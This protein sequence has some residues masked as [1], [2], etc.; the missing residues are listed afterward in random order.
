MEG[1]CCPTLP[2]VLDVLSPGFG[3]GVYFCHRAL[4]HWHAGGEQGEWSCWTLNSKAFS[5]AQQE[6]LSK[7]CALFFGVPSSQPRA[8]GDWTGARTLWPNVNPQKTARGPPQPC[9][10]ARSFFLNP[11]K[12]PRAFQSGSVCL[13]SGAVTIHLLY[14]PRP[15]P[16]THTSIVSV[17]WNPGAGTMEGCSL[18]HLGELQNYFIHSSLEIDRYKKAKI[19]SPQGLENPKKGSKFFKAKPASRALIGLKPWFPGQKPNGLLSCYATTHRACCH[20]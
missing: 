5:P 19:L 12:D 15:P 18:F 14:P 11:N 16:P 17:F 7:A 3:S 2:L 13:T 10:L 4:L 9:T 20:S 8:L 6:Q 1:S